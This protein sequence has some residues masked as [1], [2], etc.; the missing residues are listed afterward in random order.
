MRL[1]EKSV[2]L[3]E[4]FEVAVLMLLVDLQVLLRI[5]QMVFEK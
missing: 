1:L 4:L 2:Q 3:G 5:R